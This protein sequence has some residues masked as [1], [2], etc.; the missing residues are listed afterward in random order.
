MEVTHVDGSKY[1]QHLY[2]GKYA[3]KYISL[4]ENM[5][6]NEIILDTDTNFLNN[7]DFVFNDINNGCAVF[8]PED[9]NVYPKYY[10]N[11][12]NWD[13]EILRIKNLLEKHKI[14]NLDLF[15]AE[16]TF[17]NY[18]AGFM[19]FNKSKHTEILKTAVDILFDENLPKEYVFFV[20]EQFAL[21]FLI[22]L[23]P[24]MNKTILPQKQW[25]NTWLMH[26]NPKKRIKILDGKF[27]LENEDGTQINYYHYTGDIGV[28]NIASGLIIAGRL[29]FL[30]ND[31]FKTRSGIFCTDKEEI[32]K[33]WFNHHETPVLFLYEYFYNNGP[34]TCPKIY[35]NVFRKNIAN[36]FKTFLG[37][38]CEDESPCVIII[39]LLYDYIDLL[40][41]KLVGNHQYYKVLDY[42][43]ITSYKTSDKTIG[44]DCGEATVSLSTTQ[45]NKYYDWFC[46]INPCNHEDI[47]VENLNGVFITTK[48][49][50]III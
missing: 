12:N 15:H 30:T 44:I 41:Y 20:L 18:N 37:V 34:T 9:G 35:N 1:P 46:S 26:K 8:A 16:Y 5:S 25:M 14:K 22:G 39:A 24:K 47:V 29:Y 7:L 23:T 17:S 4:L 10:Y 43:L 2:L 31:Y 6:E 28:P 49:K 45:S 40:E 36:I 19:G 33:L 3:F 32:K 11:G 48:M 42:L 27:V 50:E 13:S 38:E 21:S